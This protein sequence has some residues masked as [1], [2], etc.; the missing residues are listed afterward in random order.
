MNLASCK[1]VRQQLAAYREQD[2]ES[3]DLSMLMEHVATCSACQA[4]QAD[5]QRSGDLIRE[6]PLI[7][8]PPTFRASVLA[9]VRSEALRQAPT[10]AEI[11]RAA[12]NPELPVVSAKAA[13]GY[14]SAAIGRPQPRVSRRL[15]LRVSLVAAAAVLLISLL[16]ARLI[17]L[18]GTSAVGDSAAS[19]SGA[20]P[21]N[22]ARYPLNSEYL[23]PTSA[24]ATSSWLVYTATSAT[25]LGE[26]VAEN[27]HTRHTAQLL[28]VPATSPLTVRAL[29]EHWVVW[30]EGD[31]TSTSPWRLYASSLDSA[32]I[33]SP[34]TLVDSGVIT[35]STLATLGGV[36]ASNDTVL[37]AGAPHSGT[38]ELLKIDLSSGVPASTV[39]ARGQV[40]GDVLTDPSFD[41]NTY[42]W[43]DVW[44]DSATGLHS[45]IWQ[46][47]GAEH[48]QDLSP[49][50]SAFDPQVSQNTLVWVDVAEAN[51]QQIANSV[52]A[53]TPDSDIEFLDSL[54]GLLDERDL[55]TGQQWQLSNRADVESVVVAGRLLLW[56]NGTETHAYD[57]T[58]KAPL[59]ANSEMH[60]ARL[61]SATSSAI[62]WLES[63][64][65]D[66]FVY[67]A[68]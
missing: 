39:I 18:I 33:S 56:Q 50:Q 21:P 5:Y 52:G 30:T 16:G 3:Q 47:D 25:H 11:S 13:S 43:A 7:V 28:L 4:V 31:G 51:L 15:G 36:W 58:R 65:V 48:N 38:G 45:T 10:L 40:S 35:S 54:G 6:L 1:W 26:I 2:W 14:R 57:L 60:S 20:T 68:A 41:H 29:T 24:M 23:L 42:Y 53:G 55:L 59:A 61:A 32:G 66:I 17:S 19:L 63:G 34:I 22:I 62:T 8:P 37:V 12:T 67:D 64:G 9:A 44:W 46:G 49:D 27:R